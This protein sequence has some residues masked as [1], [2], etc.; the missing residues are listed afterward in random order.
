MPQNI[1]FVCDH[2]NGGGAERINLEL[3]EEFI[4]NGYSVTMLLLDGKEQ[5]MEI[6]E[7]LNI[8]NLNIKFNNSLFRNKGKDISDKDRKLIFD[9]ECELDPVLTVISYAF[10]YWLADCFFKK[11]TWLWVHGDLT[12][13]NV[14]KRVGSKNIFSYLNEYRRSKIEKKVFYKLFNNRNIIVVNEG[15]VDFYK[16]FSNPYIVEFIPNGVS[17]RRFLNIENEDIDKEYDMIFVGRF[18]S[19]KRPKIAIQAFLDS[20]LKGKM[21][22]VGDG[23][24][25]EELVNF[26]KDKNAE[27]KIIFLGWKKNP[28][29]YI[30]KSKILI[31]TSESEGFPLVISESI[32]LD[33]PVVSYNSSSGI[34]YQLS[35]GQLNQGLVEKNNYKLLVNTIEKI[36]MYPYEITEKDKERLSMK[37]CFE[38]FKRITG[39]N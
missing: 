20:N 36:Y 32:K 23:I 18:S 3:A 9:L 34:E 39:I 7:G 26:V 1:I 17:E 24:L 30:K 5:G 13:F 25:K 29:Y 8:V 6:P 35:S 37:N 31:L 11:N 33:V 27:N 28:E 10:G 19:E 16:E 21:A 4:N 22:I 2:L 14:F 38:Q 15:L 12:N